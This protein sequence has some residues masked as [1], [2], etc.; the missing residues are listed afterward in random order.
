MDCDLATNVD[1]PPAFGVR[2]SDDKL[3]LHVSVADPHAD[4]AG[5]AARVARELAPLGLAVEVGEDVLGDLLAAACRPGEHLVDHPLLTGDLPVPQRDGEV[6]WQGDYFA[7]GFVCDEDRDRVDY[8]ERAERRAV[9]QDQ[10]VA[11]LLL[12]REGKPGRTLQGDAVPVPKPRP[13][14]LRA[15][16][17]VRTEKLDDR[18][19][20]FAAIPGRLNVKDGQVA[21]DEVYLIRGNVGLATG[22]IHHTGA[23]VV[24]GDVEGGAEITCDG[25]IL[26][27]GMVEPS[28]IVCGANLTVGGGIVGAKDHR[29]EVAGE[30]QAR[31]LNEVTLRCGGDVT[32]VSQ[33]DHCDLATRGRVVIP[34]GRI[35]GG[36]TKA[37]RGIQVGHAGSASATGTLLVAGADWRF[38]QTQ[39]E[40]R[41]RL[42]KLHEAHEL[43]A[44]SVANALGQGVL[45]AEQS[46]SVRHLK[47]KI[48]QVEQ[49]LKV[50]AE[51][52]KRETDESN[53]GALREIA[54]FLKLWTGVTFRLGAC[55]A[56]SNCTYEMP[57]LVAVRRDEVRILPMGDLNTPDEPTHR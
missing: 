47:A 4:L 48:A 54:V 50:E 11:V 15:G 17:G 57:R 16:K 35:A 32:I 23:L 42:Q 44:K 39:L 10:L 2:L 52:D 30:V 45:N 26:I 22:N 20:F 51:T 9:V 1:A 31:Y 37:Y 43:L 25:D 46:A 28:T 33:I 29:I 41:A 36:T 34:R 55:Q 56:V 19:N 21:V 24:Q 53:C 3:T 27:K 38:E 40:R 6:Q 5:A 12:P 7:T 14:K 49:A 13:A 8:W 18:V